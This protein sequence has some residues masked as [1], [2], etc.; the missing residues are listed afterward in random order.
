MYYN[1]TEGQ[2]NVEIGK[3]YCMQQNKYIFVE[4]SYTVKYKL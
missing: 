3:V 1:I 2:N 4:N